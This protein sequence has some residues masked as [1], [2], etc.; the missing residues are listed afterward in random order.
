MTDQWRKA[1]VMSELGEDDP[2]AA[3]IDGRDIGIHMVAG[4]VYAIDDICPHAF[5]M[6]SDGFADGDELTCPKHL[7]VFHIPT[8]KCLKGPRRG[9]EPLLP[10]LKTHGVRIDGNDIL[11]KLSD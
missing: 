1:G 5:V 10:G 4:A 8:G 3:K 11:V 9:A 2:I 6:L 7:A